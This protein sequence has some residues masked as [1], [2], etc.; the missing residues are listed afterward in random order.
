MSSISDDFSI[1]VVE[2]ED[3]I[4]EIIITYLQLYPKFKYIVRARDPVE[5]MQKLHNQDF[6]LIITDIGLPKKDGISFIA[7]LRKVPKYFKQKIIVISGCL[8]HE[9][10]MKC[11]QNN[12]KH[13]IVKPF[14]ARQL[15]I[16]SIGI[17]R[18]EKQIRSTVDTI[19]A[20]MAK[21]FLTKNFDNQKAIIDEDIRE[22]IELSEDENN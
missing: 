15:L 11:I 17:L 10:T 9:T 21:R 14:T 8:T 12:V 18:A 1:L 19:I 22:L 13:I 2:D 5:A 4:A 20:K 6:D 3:K 16:K 7:S